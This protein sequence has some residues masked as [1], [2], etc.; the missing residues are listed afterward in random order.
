MPS[1]D[2]AGVEIAYDDMGKGRPIV[3]VHGFAA[4]F[5]MNWR[6]PGWVDALVADGR[7]VLGL[8]CRGHG[9]SAKPHDPAAYG[10]SQ[11]VDDVVRLMD[12]VG[13]ERADLMGY[14][15]GGGIATQLLVHHSDRFHAVIL[16]G[17]G[18]GSARRDRGSI[19][20]AMQARDASTAEDDTAR[21]FRAFAEAGGNDLEALAAMMR[22]MR[23]PAETQALA[24]V[25][26]PVL[27][28][29]GAD[30]ALVADPE[31]LGKSIPGARTV[32]IPE[33]DHLTVVGDPRYKQA[34]L[35][36]LAEHPD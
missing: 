26:L 22:S 34:V 2:S 7:R 27:I 19:A 33:R 5:E 11:M 4:S 16:G 30:D 12:H 20:N 35:A 9:R 29:V 14:S 24:S 32:V 1:F 15:M 25:K 36:F 28:V 23:A 17:I 3:L 6:A 13:L 21:A 18:G 10:G 8:D 31:A